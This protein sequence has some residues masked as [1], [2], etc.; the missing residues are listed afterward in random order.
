MLTHRA[1]K[2]PDPKFADSKFGARVGVGLDDKTFSVLITAGARLMF[3][4]RTS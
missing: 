4:T 1:D 2:R 3:H